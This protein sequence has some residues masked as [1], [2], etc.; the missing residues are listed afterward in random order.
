MQLSKLNERRV[1]MVL[2][3]QYD[4]TDL[5]KRI[6]E[7]YGSEK[8]FASDIGMSDTYLSLILNNKA[9]FR[10][11]TI[12]RASTALGIAPTKISKYFFCEKS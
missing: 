9:E 3:K 7:K 8:N 5:R 2:R 10:Q 11:S 1:R 12:K 4:Y 6:R